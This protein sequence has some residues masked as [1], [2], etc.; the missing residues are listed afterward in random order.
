MYKSILQFCEE[1]IIK[2]EDVSADFYEKP[3][4]IAGFVAGV[5]SVFIKAG[6]EFI[7]EIFSE[8]NQMIR[9]S[10]ARKDKWEVVRTDTKKM[11]C[12]LGEFTYKKTLF[13][14]KKTGE[15]TYLLDHYLGIESFARLT[16][17]AQAKMLEEAVQTSYRRAGESTSLTDNVSKGTVKNR[18]HE[19]QFPKAEYPEKRKK[20][21]YLYIDADEDHVPLQF[22]ESKGDLKTDRN[23]RTINNVQT[24]LVY[25]Y[26]GIEPEAPGSKRYKLVNAHYFSGVYEGK[27][28]ENLWEEVY[29]Y[30]E[31]TYDLDSVKKI[32]LNAD[33][34]SW[35]KAGKIK[36]PG[37]VSVL[38]EYHINKYLTSMTTHL[39]DS[40]EDGRNLL[41]D[42]IRRGTKMEFVEAV[43]RLKD[44][45]EDINAVYRIETG[46]AYIMS[47]W[48][49]AKI[50]LN[51]STG[52][53]GSSTEGH[54]SHVLASRMSSRPMGWS[55][56][57]AD[58]MA[59][60]RAYHWNGG[61]MLDLVRYQSVV[62]CTNKAAKDEYVTVGQIIKSEKEHHVHGKYYDHI[63]VSL[64][65][66]TRKILAIRDRMFDL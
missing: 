53:I 58:K 35:I 52:V 55:K 18:L 36:I 48:T 10:Q 64:P 5:S 61:N 37:I 11:L 23:G 65:A 30:I 12:S 33:G 4:N 13:K 42:V 60:L 57:G 2:F 19:L 39:Y 49:A 32:Y 47:N 22:I 24:K 56:C 16:E 21:E 38:D 3:D 15:R 43:E 51:R 20:V 46:A 29:E 17:D 50:R 28:N 14:N 63:Q 59:R 40:A 44:Y 31:N 8:L 1:G 62:K 26:E 45:A 9:E 7:G 25:V 6:C 66:Q 54:V 27:D 41:R 34:G